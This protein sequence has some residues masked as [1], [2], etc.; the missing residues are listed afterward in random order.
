MQN[1]PKGQSFGMVEVSLVKQTP[2]ARRSKAGVAPK[3][4]PPDKEIV[5]RVE[6]ARPG[7]MATEPTFDRI[8]P[9]I[10]LSKRC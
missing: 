8:I 10:A 7:A 5:R 6:E 9:L 2:S 1:S 3:A 4:K